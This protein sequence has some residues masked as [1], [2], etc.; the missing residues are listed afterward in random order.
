MKITLQQ[1]GGLAAARRAPLVLDTAELGAQ[2]AQVEALAR[3]VST[4]PGS[5]RPPH[6]D[7]MAYTLTI[8]GDDGTHDIRTMETDASPE[9]ATLVQQVRRSGKPGS[10]DP[11]RPG[12][13][14][15]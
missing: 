12:G 13:P 3:T 7:E 9:F 8:A 1:H 10:V 2:R 6:P 5:P 14:S 11:S 15:P 4:Q